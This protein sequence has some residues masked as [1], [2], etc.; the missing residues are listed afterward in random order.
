MSLLDKHKT[1]IQIL[2]VYRVIL[3]ENK[4]YLVYSYLNIANKRERNSF[5]Y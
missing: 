5:T 2:D 3:F 4:T 1:D